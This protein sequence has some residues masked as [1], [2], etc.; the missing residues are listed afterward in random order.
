M[1]LPRAGVDHPAAA[2]I[3][4]RGTWTIDAEAAMPADEGESIQKEQELLEQIEAE[5]RRIGVGDYLAQL[6]ITLSS[7]SLPA[8]G[9]DARDGGRS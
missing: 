4:S 6:L 7:M 9:S 3:L 1:P 2:P 8:L 5:L